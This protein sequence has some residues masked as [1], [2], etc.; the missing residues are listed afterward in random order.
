MKKMPI[1]ALLITTGLAGMASTTLTVAVL[2]LY[3]DGATYDSA[4]ETW[5]VTTTD[6]FDL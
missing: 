4:T 1:L 2:Q 3:I 5:V 6:P